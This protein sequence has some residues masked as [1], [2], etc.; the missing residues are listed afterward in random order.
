VLGY[1]DDLVLLPLGVA[2]V[3]RLIPPEVMAEARER[4]RT[5]PP[6]AGSGAWVATAAIIACWLAVAL[7]TVWL[8]RRWM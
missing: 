6:R 3:L 4:A 8:A 5:Q 1:L 7:V 2:L